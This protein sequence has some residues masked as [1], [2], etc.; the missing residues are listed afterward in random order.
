MPYVGFP[1][2]CTLFLRITS[3]NWRK[4]LWSNTCTWDF[5]GWQCQ[6]QCLIHLFTTGWTQGM[7]MIYDWFFYSIH[8]V[9]INFYTIFEIS[10]INLT[11]RF[12]IFCRFRSYIKALFLSIKMACCN[13]KRLLRR[14]YSRSSLD[15]G[16]IPFDH[17]LMK[18]EMNRRVE[19]YTC[20]SHIIKAAAFVVLSKLR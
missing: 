4:A 20:N 6:T 7:S 19:Q 5:T 15:I 13:P 12:C 2:I 10:K 9:K 11:S 3:T 8:D 18:A 16:V 14:S 17:N 1:T